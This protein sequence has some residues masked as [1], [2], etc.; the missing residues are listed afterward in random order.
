MFAAGIDYEA[1]DGRVVLKESS[2][3]DVGTTLQV[4]YPLL[5]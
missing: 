5:P 1:R 2:V 4:C 3:L